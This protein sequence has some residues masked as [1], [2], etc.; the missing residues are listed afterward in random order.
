MDCA[1]E[2]LKGDYDCLNRGQATAAGAAPPGASEKIRVLFLIDEFDGA[3]GGTEQHLLFLLKELPRRPVRPAV[4]G[5]GRN[6]AV[7]PRGLPDQAR[8]AARK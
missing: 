8:D 2:L 6:P 5:A 7:R 1:A 3:E 4:W